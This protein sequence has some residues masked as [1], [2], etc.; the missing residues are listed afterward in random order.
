VGAHASLAAA[1]GIGV[2][3]SGSLGGRADTRA[4]GFALAAAGGIAAS[5]ARVEVTVA[6]A[7]SAGARA[8]FD[9]PP[10]TPSQILDVRATTYGR[11][12]PL[13]G[14][15]LVQSSS[16][17]SAGVIGAWSADPTA[18]AEQRSR[19]AGASTLR[20]SPGR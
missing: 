16:T 18:E 5:T 11:G 4:D 13:Q 1:V 15:A 20:W 8:S 10:G 19:D 12:V 6:N 7:A 14:T 3:T 2:G 9:V 17:A